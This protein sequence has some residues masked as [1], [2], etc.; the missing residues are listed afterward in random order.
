VAPGGR[1]LFVSGQVKDPPEGI[2]V[3]RVGVRNDAAALGQL[4]AMA[5]AGQLTLRVADVVGFDGA[6][7]AHR[8][9]AVGGLRGRMVLQ[10]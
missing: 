8:R 6:P 9:M 5:S 4:A 1:L 2:Q 3:K 7:D 10:P